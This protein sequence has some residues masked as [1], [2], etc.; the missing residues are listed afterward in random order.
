MISRR[1][2]VGLALAGLILPPS[3][4]SA[5]HSPYGLNYANPGGAAGNAVPYANG[6]RGG[7]PQFIP[8][9]PPNGLHPYPPPAVFVPVQPPYN[10]PPG[11]AELVYWCDNP[12]GYYP[13]V[14]TCSGPWR[15]LSATQPR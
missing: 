13:N 12:S 5:Q 6:W 2:R 1:I 11:P 3:A 7:Q 8:P 4:V 9:P 10:S 15:E 14:T